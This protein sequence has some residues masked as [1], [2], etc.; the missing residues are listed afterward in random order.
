NTTGSQ[1]FQNVQVWAFNRTEMESGATA[2]VVSFSLP[3]KIGG[4]AGVTVFSLLPSNLR[5]NGSA[6][7]AGTPNYFA[8]IFGIF[9]ARVWKFHVDY[10]VP[11]NSTFTGPSDVTISSFNVGPSSV[12]EQTGNNVDTLTYRLMMQNQY[13]NVNGTESLWLTHTIGNGGS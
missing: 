7:A 13:Q 6:P 10:G 5:T 12:P 4:G 8:S 9:N 1:A 3:Q 2:H 11:A